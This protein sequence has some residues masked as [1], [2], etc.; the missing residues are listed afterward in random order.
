MDLEH[1]LGVAL[2]RARE[3]ER[4]DERDVVG[5]DDL[6]VHE[7]VHDSG[8][9]RV[10]GLPANGAAVSTVSQQRD[11]PGADAVRRPLVEHLVDLRLVDDAGDVAAALVHDLDERAEDRARTSAPARRSG[12]ALR[13]AEE[14]RDPVGERLA[15]ARG[16]N[17]GADLDAGRSRPAAADP[18]RVLDAAPRPRARRG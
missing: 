12:S 13:P 10:E 7:V 14:L 4:A 2:A 11:L 8:V 5:D 6:G 17:H 18:P 3:V 9:Q 1:V 16:V 15:V